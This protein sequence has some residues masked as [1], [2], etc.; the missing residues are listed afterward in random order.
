[1]RNRHRITLFASLALGGFF[2]CLPYG[3]IS[4]EPIRPV[5]Q[6]PFPIPQPHGHSAVPHTG[7]PPES[8]TPPI[9]HKAPAKK[10]L[11]KHV[12]QKKQ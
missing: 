6:A 7:P 4:Q 8:E 11:V 2:M 3:I 1:M 9:F 10:P 12:R 5:G